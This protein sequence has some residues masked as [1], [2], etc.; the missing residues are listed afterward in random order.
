MNKM[1]KNFEYKRGKNVKKRLN[2][3][4]GDFCCFTEFFIKRKKLN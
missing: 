3:M 1:N 4:L 2:V